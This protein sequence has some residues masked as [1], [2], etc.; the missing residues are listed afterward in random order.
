M[1]RSEILHKGLRTKLD[2]L[3][4]LI[5]TLEREK[6]KERDTDLRETD[7]AKEVLQIAREYYSRH[8]LQTALLV[9][10]RAEWLVFCGEQDLNHRKMLITEIE[11]TLKR[12]RE[13]RQ[14]S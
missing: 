7:E 2:G 9:A 5:D 10:M 11:E 4:E 6:N 8:D 12:E 1:G 13:K 3:D 14:R